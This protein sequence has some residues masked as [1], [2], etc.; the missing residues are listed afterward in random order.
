MLLQQ[1]QQVTL[2][3]RLLPVV[4]YSGD[5]VFDAAAA[6]D[7]RVSAQSSER[8]ASHAAAV[9]AG[10]HLLQV[11]VRPA[12]SAAGWLDAAAAHAPAAG[13]CLLQQLLLPAAAVCPASAE[14]QGFSWESAPVAAVAVLLLLQQLQ[15]SVLLLQLLQSCLG[16][17]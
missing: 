9:V 3:L 6:G 4:A 7:C 11:T 14:L 17:H 12:S 1:Q 8:A 15:A 2:P 10:T 13:C 16:Y 5:P